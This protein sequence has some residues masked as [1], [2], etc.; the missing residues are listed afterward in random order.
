MKKP[1]PTAAAGTNWHNGAPETLAS[2]IRKLEDTLSPIRYVDARLLAVYYEIPFDDNRPTAVTVDPR[3]ADGARLLSIRQKFNLIR[4]LVDTA[5]S[6]IVQVPAVEI[7]TVGGSRNQQI[8]AE[9]LGLFVDGVF[10]EN[11]MELLAW[12]CFT[13]SCLTRVAAVLVDVEG[14]VITIRRKFPHTIYWNPA[15]G[16]NPRNLYLRGPVPLAAL[17]AAYPDQEKELVEAPKYKPDPLFEGVDGVYHHLP[18]EMRELNEAFRLADHGD[19]KDKPSGK[20]VATVG[21]VVLAD[22][23]YPHTF[24]KL[25]PLRWQPSYAS[26]AGKPAGDTLLSYQDTLDRMSDVIDEAQTK[27]CVPWTFLYEGGGV[28]KSQLTNMCN[29]VLQ[30]S[31]PGLEP[32][33]VLGQALPPEY[34]QREQA[35]IDRAAQFMGISPNVAAGTRALNITSAKG[36]REV[37]SISDQ[38]QVLHMRTM[39]RWL[40][41]IAKTVVAVAD[42]HFQGKKGAQVRAP[43]GKLLRQITWSEIDYKKDAFTVKVDSINALSRHPAARIDELLELKDAGVVDSREVM[44]QMNVKDLQSVREAAFAPEDLADKLIDKA[45][46]GDY[47]APEPYQG[48]IGLQYVISKGGERYTHE[49]LQEEPSEHLND[50]RKLIEQAKSTLAQLGPGQGAPPA[51][52]DG[53]PPPGPGA[54]PPGAPPPMDG[55]PPPGPPMPGPP[56]A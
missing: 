53:A 11:E 26:F 25:V 16:P 19:P 20:Y 9:S 28:E 7:S 52:G 5:A 14:D 3:I 39:D 29:Q 56:A 40:E 36:Q 42:Y 43:G 46:A 30:V 44:R 32:K 33:R 22:D 2:A 31:A 35:I 13:D 55:G 17:I 47:M 34:Y 45:L 4:S 37:K 48:S 15:E 10:I 23:P 12:M 1:K 51:P 6:Q 8:S 41:Q 49:M 50:L 24:H 54:L 38:R 18:S 21:N 27:G